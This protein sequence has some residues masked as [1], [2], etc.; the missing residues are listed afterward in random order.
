MT[1]QG[2]GEAKMKQFIDTFQV[3]ECYRSAVGVDS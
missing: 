1:T 3:L 2:Y